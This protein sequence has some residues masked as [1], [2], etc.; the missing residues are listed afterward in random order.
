MEK[1]KELGIFLVMDKKGNKIYRN[2]KEESA[3]Y[4]QE[5]YFSGEFDALNY[6]WHE[7]FD[8]ND[9]FDSIG[10]DYERMGCF[11]KE[12]DIVLDIGANLG[13]FERRARF[14]GASRVIC[15]EPVTPT[16]ECLV[17]NVENKYDTFNVGISGK[18]SFLDFELHSDYSQVGGGSIS[19]YDQNQGRDIIYVQKNLCLGINELFEGGLFERADFMKIDIEGGEVDLLTSIKDEHLSSLRCI[20][21]EFHNI[22]PD[23]DSFQDNFISRCHSLGFKTFIL[24]H[25]DGNLRTLNVWKE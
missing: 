3:G 25:G 8:F 14:R 9:V 4:T 24:F 15:F 19:N 23:F 17:E 11:I 18:T 7:N 10:C 1:N 22:F 13:V 16:Y 12:G 21:C 6:V 5:R 20:A 2:L